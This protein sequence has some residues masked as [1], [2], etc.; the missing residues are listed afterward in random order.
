MVCDDSIIAPVR[1]KVN[2]KRK[3]RKE[4][5]EKNGEKRNEQSATAYAREEVVAD[6]M[7]TV[8]KDGQ[9][10][11]D[12][13]TRDKSLFAKIKDWIEDFIRK[14]KKVYANVKPGT[15][16][17][18][19][20]ADVMEDM[21]ELERLFADALV[22]V[23]ER[24][25]TEGV[26]AGTGVN[27]E[28]VQVSERKLSVE[29]RRDYDKPITMQDIE[30]LRSIGRKSINDFTS[31]DI[32]K[33]RKWAYK[34]YQEMGVKSP[35]FRAWFGDWRS[36][37]KEPLTVADIPAYIGTNE[38]RKQ[39]RGDVINGDTGW[40]IRVSREGETNTISHAGAGRLS[41][42][43]LAGI[44]SLIQN[45]VHLDS[46][47]HEH[48]SNN[49]KEENIAFDHKLYALG[50]DAVGNIALYKITVEEYFQSKTEPNK[51]RFHNL[52]Y[53]EK[54]ADVT[55]RR[56]FSQRNSGGSTNGNT[57]ATTYSIADLLAFVKQYDKE[58]SPKPVHEA[59]LND[60]GTPKVFYHGTNAEFTTFD[61]K[62]IGS[63]TDDGIYGNGF[64]FTSFR[65]QADQYGKVKEYHLNLK[66][67]LVLSNYNSIEELAE[68]LEMSESN[69]SISQ[70][71]IRPRYAFINSFASHVRYAGFDGVIVDY[72]KS[73]EIVVFEPTQIKSAT[74]N[75][76]TFDSR[77]P[78]IRY[79][80]EDT[81][82][83][84][85]SPDA[86]ESGEG[87]PTVEEL[88]AKLEQMSKSY[89]SRRKRLTGDAFDRI[90][91][92]RNDRKSGKAQTMLYK[93]QIQEEARK[94]AER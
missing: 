52:K 33:A 87:V 24:A 69:F 61:R 83:G 45:A 73:D 81:T 68:A 2:K 86:R 25:K 71:I 26:E 18:Q 54:V 43:G 75:I 39:Q 40:T 56:T 34:F 46:E 28:R 66:N 79:S 20:M 59:M 19:V 92:F 11:E 80:V 22:D 15:A 17:G 29:E 13:A 47:V 58:F 7:E 70:G 37:D 16:A 49:A 8:L 67:P 84:A 48:H 57:S 9:V 94:L 76:G 74:D 78:D 21:T 72:G 1:G 38:A 4:K 63:N 32:E 50:E 65:N 91:A 36:N 42:Y 30:V 27:S 55:G 12:L 60:D 14:L 10:L 90:R 93:A 88:T 89:E 77:N 6:A 51:K 41:E 62:K 85:E 23:G 64:Y 35:F 44:G 3:K 5:K 82:E 53:I 31:A